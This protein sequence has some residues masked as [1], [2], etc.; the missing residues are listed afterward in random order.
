[1]SGNTYDLKSLSAPIMSGTI[2]KLVALLSNSPAGAPLLRKMLRDAGIVA[3]RKQYADEHHPV[4]PVGRPHCTPAATQGCPANPDSNA[5][6]QAV[7][8]ATNQQSAAGFS[9][10]SAAD[11]VS[12]YQSGHCSPVDVAERVLGDTASLDEHNPP[13]RVFIAQN[14]DDVIRQAEASAE[15]YRAGK[16]LSP[17]DGVP[18]AVKDELDQVPYPTT[19]G[20]S[21]I[22]SAPAAADAEIVARLRRAGAVLIGKANM[23]EIGL[24]VTGLNPH[25][26]TA[27]NPYNPGHATG[28]SSSG[29][30]A[31]VAAGLCPIAVGAD[32]GG[33][34]RLPA[35][36]C[37]VVGLKATFGRLS[38]H[39]AAPLCWSLAHVGPIAGSVADAA[40]A[41]AVMA[42]PDNKD[43]HSVTQPPVHLEEVN[44][45]DLSGVR[46]GVF[47]PWFEDADAALVANAD[48]SLN[49]LTDAG[50][51]IVD[52][53]I[54]E[55]AAMRTVHLITIA[56]EMAAAQMPYLKEH[57]ADYAADSRLTLAIARQLT[58]TDYINAQRHRIRLTQHFLSVLD[59][60]DVIATPMTG[61][62]SPKLPEHAMK[63]GE[64]NL[65]LVDRIIRFAGPAN[66]TGL[67]AIACPSGYDGAG[68]PTALQLMGRHWEEHQL[69][70]LAAVVESQVERRKPTVYNTLVSN[71]GD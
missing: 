34:I 15:R 71:A 25:H 9:F 27:R 17:L 13:M 67:P 2:L 46:I 40:L 61:C 16:V 1:M 55:L 64:S 33:S 58:A 57:G 38:E 69:I 43:P 65:G 18:I 53:E 49:T 59:N 30:A 35:A 12:A 28:G 7:D 3:F 70:R 68:L 60:V 52:I 11:F 5:V 56:S 50:A 14:R 42:G 39:G 10:E 19:V 26:G 21:F 24:G 22:G 66:V 4:G 45:A 62:T 32:G 36:F 54:P 29:S 47:R 6:Q 31:A 51:Q 20:T 8:L 37:G 23:H 41:Y 48:A 44:N 63:T